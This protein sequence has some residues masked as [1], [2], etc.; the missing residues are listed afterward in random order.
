MLCFLLWYCCVFVVVI[1]V[2]VLLFQFTLI[3]TSN[4]WQTSH[5]FGIIQPIPHKPDDFFSVRMVKIKERGRKREGGKE[6]R[7]EGGK[8]GRRGGGKER[9]RGK[10]GEKPFVG[11]FKIQGNQVRQ[12]PEENINQGRD[13]KKKKKKKKPART[14]SSYTKTAVFHRSCLAIRKKG[15]Q[16]LECVPSVNDIFKQSTHACFQWS[17]WGGEKRVRERNETNWGNKIKNR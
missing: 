4:K 6:G 15:M 10:R 13:K 14:P 12:Q 16:F 8:E 17:V 1:I 3:K 2:V 5:F 11:C 9:K 7:R